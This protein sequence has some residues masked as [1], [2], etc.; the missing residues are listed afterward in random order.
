MTTLSAKCEP[1]AAKRTEKTLTQQCFETFLM[2]EIKREKKSLSGQLYPLPRTKRDNAL[3]T[4][5]IT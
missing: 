4:K 3:A 1:T 2:A 5:K